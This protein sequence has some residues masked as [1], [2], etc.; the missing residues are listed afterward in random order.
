MRGKVLKVAAVAVA[1]AFTSMTATVLAKATSD[2]KEKGR[3]KKLDAELA[4]IES[5]IIEKDK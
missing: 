1:A 3:R 4:K 5:K 2:Y